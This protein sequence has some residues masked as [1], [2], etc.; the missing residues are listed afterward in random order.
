MSETAAA[1]PPDEPSG[2]GKGER[3]QEIAHGA[4]RGSVAAMAMT[5]MRSFTV[6]VGLVEEAPPRA[7]LRQKSKGLYR[8]TPRRFRRVAQELCHWG[9]G[10]GGGAIFAMLP[11]GLR[12]QAWSGPAYGLG[13]WLAFEAGVA[14]ALG[15]SQSRKVRPVDRVA[16]AADHLLYGFVL[17]ELR[18]RPRR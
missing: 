2:K 13:I 3:A 12:R 10:A 7:V 18:R 11:Q 15:L 5:G 16:L 17:A 6:S 1:P 9:Y 14:P 4:L 8:I